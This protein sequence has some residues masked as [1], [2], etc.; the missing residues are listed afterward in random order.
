MRGVKRTFDFQNGYT[1]A[2]ENDHVRSSGIAGQF[3]LKNRGVLTRFGVANFQFTAFPLQPWNGLV[4]SAH[5][6]GGS[7]SDEVL[8]LEAN[9]AG[10]ALEKCPRLDCHP[11]RL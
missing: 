7:V 11:N 10:S 2:L 3:V 9:N 4:P 1:A 6:L 8:Q 5:L